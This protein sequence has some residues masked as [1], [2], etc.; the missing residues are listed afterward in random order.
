MLKIVQGSRQDA[1]LTPT[2]VPKQNYD[3]GYLLVKQ[4]KMAITNA[5]LF[6]K[7][8]VTRPVSASILS[9]L[10]SSPKTTCSSPDL[11]ATCDSFSGCDL[12]S[13][14]ESPSPPSRTPPRKSCL[15]F[16]AA[17]PKSSPADLECILTRSKAQS[18]STSKKSSVVGDTHRNYNKLLHNE[19]APTTETQPVLGSVFDEFGEANSSPVFHD[20]YRI[21]QPK[22]LV[23][24]CLRKEKELR[25]SPAQEDEDQD[26]AG[27]DVDY[28]SE[29]E[30]EDG[31]DESV[32]GD[33]VDSEEGE[34]GYDRDD[35]DSDAENKSAREN[36]AKQSHFRIN[37][38]IGNY[39]L[40]SSA[41]YTP[42]RD[43]VDNFVP[44]TLDE[45]QL[46]LLITAHSPPSPPS[47]HDIDP[48]YPSDEEEDAE[49]SSRLSP[50]PASPVRFLSKRKP[51]MPRRLAN[52]SSHAI[53][54]GLSR[55][56]ALPWSRK[57]YNVHLK[58][59][60]TRYNYR[61]QPRCAAI[62]IAKS[63]DKRHHPREK[64]DD[65]DNCTEEKGLG[66]E[67][68]AAMARRLT[69]KHTLGLWAVSV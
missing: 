35:D 53:S 45:D 20:S 9:S 17:P 19:T 18:L 65:A 31:E 49:L 61:D 4:P 69:T 15:S 57:R 51:L 50:P 37:T 62:A 63:A 6:K 23:D 59:P 40:S 29:V 14:S 1:S 7:Q 3:P 39:I 26:E 38:S 46:E 2:F 24:D 55:T 16:A 21:G 44:G 42:S 33:D 12:T 8:S 27:R 36:S 52:S 11:S 64:R 25:I 22:K 13:R 60:V 30:E 67:A 58:P 48:T 41:V 5:E 56:H 66:V 10:L 68:M 47:P 54:N 34:T 32:S 28:A 43:V